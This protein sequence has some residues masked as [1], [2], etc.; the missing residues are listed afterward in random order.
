[1]VPPRI[2]CSRGGE[3]PCQSGAD[4]PTDEGG[5][6]YGALQAELSNHNEF[7]AP[8][9]VAT[10]LLNREF[11]AHQLD[12]TW[13]TDVTYLP[14]AEG[15][16]YVAVVMDL[17]SRKIVGWIMRDTLHTEPV[18]AVLTMTQHTRRP[19]QGLLHHSDHGVQYAITEHRRALERLQALQS[20]NRKGDCLENASMERSFSTIKLEL[21]PSRAI[22]CLNGSGSS[23]PASVTTP[24][25]GTLTG[26]VRKLLGELDP[27]QSSYNFSEMGAPP[28]VIQRWPETGVSIPQVCLRQDVVAE[29]DD[30]PSLHADGS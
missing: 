24:A 8:S 18:V 13:R 26:P 17:F 19:A 9:L 5:G 27:P 7:R 20:M 29:A 15:W 10:T 14:V 12:Q 6:T 3:A 22:W 16:M 11:T 30:P 28:H 2:G 25:W 1:M 23:T 21:A 4:H